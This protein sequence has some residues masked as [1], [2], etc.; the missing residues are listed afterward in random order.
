M[1]ND[2]LD[3]RTFL[4]IGGGALL[5]CGT[6]RVLAD[7]ST[8]TPGQSESPR[9]LVL[10]SADLELVLDAARALPIEYRL[11][12]LHTSF[13]GDTSG[14]PL[15]ATICDKQAW[16]FIPV[17]I[18]VEPA[19]SFGQE[20]V[21]SSLD[22]PCTMSVH[23]R[24]AVRF[25]LGYRVDGAS[26]FV[27]MY[28]VRE[29]NGYE[30]I[31]VA[32]PALVTVTEDDGAAWLAHG[33]TGGSVAA[34]SSA[35]PGS[36]QPNRFWG[37][38]LTTLPVLMLGNGQAVCTMEIQSFMNG[39]ELTVTG[40]AGSRRAAIGTIHT[41]R[42]NGSSCWDMN[43]GDPAT[44]RNCGNRNTPNL[45]VEQSAGRVHS[46]V[47]VGPSC[48]LDFT[49][50]R[51]RDGAA[52]WLDGAQVVRGRMPAMRSHLYDNAFVYGILLDQPL[53]EKPTATFDDCEQIIRNMAALTDNAK[54]IVHLWGWQFHGKDSGYPD[55]R[56]VDQRIG[57]Y[58]G[59]MR[60]M[61]NA[62]QYNCTVTLSDNYD[63]A[64]KSSPEWNANWI[65]RRPDGELWESR[66]WT[67]ENSYILGM[68][69][70]VA[71]AGLNRVRYTCDR[72]KLPETTHVD[73]LSYYSIRNDWD[74]Q[75]PASGVKDLEARYRIV[76]E[77]NKHGVDVS[78][79]ALRYA[80]L[81]IIS[82]FWYMTGPGKCPFGGKPIPLVATIYRK[83][84]VWGQSGRTNGFADAMLKMLFYNGYTHA[85]FRDASDLKQ[86]TDLYYLMMVPWF[87]LHGRNVEGFRRDGERTTIH[88]E[89]NA[90]VDLDWGRQTY[91]VSIN[92]V[93]IA[94]DMATYCALDENRIAL[95]ATSARE[96]T[97]EIPA[98]WPTDKI[99]AVALSPSG[100]Q[101]VPV[102]I[103]SGSVVVG[104]N[105]REPVIVR[106]RS[107]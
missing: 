3:R 96:L 50:D 21:E 8:G 83:S 62:R 65:A 17:A 51:N 22:F 55:V 73:V 106:Y 46:A 60:L 81:G 101:P 29:E 85:S 84:A 38:V 41:H 45:R 53:F 32:M 57:G 93:E 86:T 61:R 87:Q 27:V 42:V 95:Y 5:A 74:P 104:V 12:R 43:T 71:A 56:E 44:T 103:R 79:E 6:Q 15:A 24:T 70:Y 52:D 31:E 105:A 14:Q 58:E 88:L 10:R 82:S 20:H 89:G 80:F 59:M 35:T 13:R 39:A 98:G 2:H 100:A 47:P 63:D 69:K 18:H 97:A 77:F 76:E 75:H 37:K 67:G 34:L 16:R 54:Q 4:Q 28:D 36:L 72:Y 102:S 92:G 66:N 33:D 64:Y 1:G 7:A 40:E 49:G 30:L 91:V 26:V 90:V 19:R 11:R 23:D 68:A 99:S 9:S 107:T 94:R 78:S 48:R 25:T